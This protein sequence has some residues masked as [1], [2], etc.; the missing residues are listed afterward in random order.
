VSVRAR[1]ADRL[2]ADTGAERLADLPVVTEGV[3][4]RIGRSSWHE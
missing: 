3:D 2:F 4:A 1:A